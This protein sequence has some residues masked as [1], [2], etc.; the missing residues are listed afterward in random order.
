M[1]RC[2]SRCAFRVCGKTLPNIPVAVGVGRTCPSQ[3]SPLRGFLPHIPRARG[4]GRSPSSHE[5]NEQ[6]QTQRE[7]LKHL[8][9]IIGG[10]APT[11]R[12]AG[13]LTSHERLIRRMPPFNTTSVGDG[14]ALMLSVGVI[15]K[16]VTSS[17]TL[18]SPPLHQTLTGF[19]AQWSLF[20]K[21][22]WLLFVFISYRLARRQTV[23]LSLL[24][25]RC[26]DA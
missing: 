13:G 24:N 1:K 9:G 3:P 14:A 7:T 26:H 4:G 5:N 22:Q 10:G 11:T 18:N 17:S 25:H 6:G 19:H 8:F 2:E 20:T 23:R 15:R 21:A 12:R 16:V